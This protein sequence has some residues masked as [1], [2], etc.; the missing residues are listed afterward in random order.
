MRFSENLNK[1]I[2][3]RELKKGKYLNKHFAKE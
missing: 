1:K 3:S 2:N